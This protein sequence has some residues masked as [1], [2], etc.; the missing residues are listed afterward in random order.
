MRAVK[1]TNPNKSIIDEI[2]IPGLNDD[3]VLIKVKKCGVCGS[4]IH[5]FKGEYTDKFPVIPGHEFSGIVEQIGRNVNKF[6]IGDEVVVEPNIACDNC[7]NCLQNRQNFCNNWNAIGVTLPGGM[8][9]Y[10]K[11]PQKNVFAAD[12]LTFEEG[13][14]V[15]PL[16]CVIHGIKK[17]GI[18]IADKAAIVGAGPIGILIQQVIKNYGASHITIIDKNKKRLEL[19]EEIGADYIYEDLNKLRENYYDVV[20]DATGVTAVMER[21]IYA[22]RSGGRILYFGVA[23][24]GTRLSLDAFKIFQKGITFMTSYTSVR[25]TY[26]AIEMLKTKKIQINNL[27]SH[28]LPLYDYEKAIKLLV[29]CD[30]AVKKILLDPAL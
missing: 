8:A 21:L 12:G 7:E 26:Q 16:S 4:D 11:V 23:G 17:I 18:N 10:T 19:A 29:A 3:E 30:D 24:Q 20:I 1:L 14:F 22:V 15:E 2:D 27:I 13:A 28:V 5:I 6:K 9:E 25:N